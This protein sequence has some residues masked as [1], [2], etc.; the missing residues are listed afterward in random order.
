M[1]DD[2]RRSRGAWWTFGAVLFLLVGFVAFQFVGT[3]VAAVFIYYATRPLYRTLCPHVPSESAA[4]LL[5]LTAM[6]LPA[7]LI[8][9]YALLLGL[10]ELLRVVETTNPGQLRGWVVSALGPYEPLFNAVTRPEQLLN[11]DSVPEI[12]DPALRAVREVGGIALRFSVHLFIGIAVAFYLLRDGHRIREWGRSTLGDRAGA[13]EAYAVAV[14][15]D[16]STVFFGNILN[17]AFTGAIGVI[18]YSAL[19]L[20]APT[21]AAVPAAA[22]LGLLTGIS[23]LVP[24]V[25][26]KL[27]YVPMLVYLVG[28]EILAETG[29]LTAVTSALTPE[30]LWFP[31]LFGVVS[32]VV[33][34]TIPDLLIRPYVSGRHIHVGLVMFAYIFGPLVFGWYGLFLGPLL[35]VLAVQFVR[36]I[37]PEL[38]RGEAIRPFAVDAAESGGSAPGKSPAE[39][40]SATVE[41]TE[42]GAVE[43]PTGGPESSGST[44]ADPSRDHSESS[45]EGRDGDS[46]DSA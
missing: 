30:V 39:A 5:S 12:V 6:A 23:S 33:V 28:R 27:V 20:V 31:A 7:L 22:L 44:T 19:N 8:S 41:S 4:A 32:L 11:A 37:V 1:D 42:G 14:D 16:L 29:T 45:G 2:W 34:D 15:R 17:A 40:G 36:L 26:M 24:V 25:G 3:L 38:L 46:S 43:K 35:L 21:G 9:S 13:V 10:E 18:T